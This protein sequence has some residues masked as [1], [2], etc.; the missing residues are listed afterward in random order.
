MGA[1][2][3]RETSSFAAHHFRPSSSVN[4]FRRGMQ[5]ADGT[6]LPPTKMSS[7]KQLNSLGNSTNTSNSSPKN[8]YHSYHFECARAWKDRLLTK[9]RRPR[10]KKSRSSNNGSKDKNLTVPFRMVKELNNPTE[11]DRLD[12]E[13]YFYRTLFQGLNTLVPYQE[14][15]G[16]TPL[17]PGLIKALDIFHGT[18]VWMLVGLNCYET[19]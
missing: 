8:S 19:N 6:P 18:G 1:K 16:E 2:H 9:F 7:E 13:H 12:Q 4:D 10:G 11:L 15:V 17:Q 5:R 3:G 14:V